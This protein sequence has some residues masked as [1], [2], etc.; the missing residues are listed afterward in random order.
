MNKAA[1]WLISVFFLSVIS[2]VGAATL[3]KPQ[4]FFS[5]YENRLLTQRPVL[6]IKALSSGQFV[7]QC[8]KYV[9]DQIYKRDLWLKAYAWLQLALNKPIVRGYHVTESCWIFRASWAINKAGDVRGSARI[10]NDISSGLK[11]KGKRV[12]FVLAP[13]RSSIITGEPLPPILRNDRVAEKRKA[14]TDTL[15][16]EAI[17]LIDMNEMFR[18]R[19]STEKLTSFYLKTDHHWKGEAAFKAYLLAVEALVSHGVEAMRPVVEED[20]HL[21]EVPKKGF[22]GSHNRQLYGLVKETDS[23]AYMKYSKSDYNAYGLF[24]GP[25]EPRY[26]SQWG[27]IYLQYED[28]TPYC[29]ADVYSGDYREITVLNPESP[30]PFHLLIIKDSYFNPIMVHFA[31]QFMKMTVMDVRQWERGAARKCIEDM[32]ADIVMFFYNDANLAG[33]CYDNLRP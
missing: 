22:I 23:I 24:Q 4:V 33:E 14:F 8:E 12:F 15:D 2:C 16:P 29:Y 25:P 1:C 31:E 19:F 6:T 10:I 17:T 30:S 20:Y 32:P 5:F 11:R 3:L 9:T 21:Q 18:Q 7:I 13:H 27:R 26:R 28:V